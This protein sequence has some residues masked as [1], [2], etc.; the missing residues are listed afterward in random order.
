MQMV[1]VVR[2]VETYR[3]GMANSVFVSLEPLGMKHV[4]SVQ[5]DL[6]QTVKT[7]LVS[8]LILTKFFQLFSSFA[9]IVVITQYLTVKRAHVYVYLTIRLMTVEI[10]F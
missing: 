7:L 9:R 4:D 2:N 10:V 3:F 8:A 5:M 6:H 1:C